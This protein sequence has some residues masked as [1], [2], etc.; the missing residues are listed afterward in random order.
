MRWRRAKT[1]GGKKRKE[2]GMRREQRK[3]RNRRGREEGRGRGRARRR[4]TGENKVVVAIKQ[5]LGTSPGTQHPHR[6]RLERR[7][8]SQPATLK[9]RSPHWDPAFGGSPKDATPC[10]GCCLSLLG[11]LLRESGRVGMLLHLMLLCHWKNRDRS[12]W[13]SCIMI[14]FG[15]FPDVA[16]TARLNAQVRDFGQRIR[17][18]CRIQLLERRVDRLNEFRE[19][20]FVVVG[21]GLVG[22][23]RGGV[24]VFL[25]TYVAQFMKQ[26][27]EYGLGRVESP[28]NYRRNAANIRD[29]FLRNR[30]LYDED[31]HH[32]KL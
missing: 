28:H 22:K 23:R 15:L 3:R 4:T 10:C 9:Q 24:Q 19:T 21:D 27:V 2:R 13:Q 11:S 25:I 12:V 7:P 16:C 20:R 26:L 18:W 32:L 17:L 1:R 31:T 14:S 30:T 5:E 8:S 29:Q 6:Q